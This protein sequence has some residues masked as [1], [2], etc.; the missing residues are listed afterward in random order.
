MCAEL[1]ITIQ[2]T[3]NDCKDT[4]LGESVLSG[5]RFHLVEVAGVVC[6]C[7]G[8]CTTNYFSN[9]MNAFSVHLSSSHLPIT[10]RH[11]PPELFT[12]P[13]DNLL[14]PY[15]RGIPDWDTQLASLFSQ[16]QIPNSKPTHQHH[17]PPHLTPNSA[18]P[19]SKRHHRSPRGRHRHRPIRL[20]RNGLIRNRT[21][22][23]DA[24]GPGTNRLGQRRGDRQV[25]GV[26]A[27]ELA[28]SGVHDD[29]GAGADAGDVAQGSA[30][31]GGE[32]LRQTRLGAG[33]VVGCVRD[34]FAG[35]GG[36]GGG[37]GGC[38]GG[39]DGG[40]VEGVVGVE[41]AAELLR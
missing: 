20:P 39:G 33:G 37:C 27:L 41:R 17:P 25:R 6:M 1:S 30:A 7:D 5:G 31:A 38:D 10:V 21:R 18:R 36:G 16:H 4:H 32:V 11:D 23:P 22:I 34:V 35:D 13:Y 24:P 29:G 28:P 12:L 19:T 40:G 3:S 15:V 8:I 14:T 26:T 2:H 9:K